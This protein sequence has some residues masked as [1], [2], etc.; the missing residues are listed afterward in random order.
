MMLVASL[1]LAD[2]PATTVKRASAKAAT[3]RLYDRESALNHRRD[4]GGQGRLWD[5]WAG[6]RG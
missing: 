2:P 3:R 4:L 5:V 1:I 6:I